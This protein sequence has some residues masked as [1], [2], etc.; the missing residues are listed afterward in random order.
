MFRYNYIL[1]K[2]PIEANRLM[3]IKN[4]TNLTNILGQDLKLGADPQHNLFKVNL[5]ELAQVTGVSRGILET[6]HTFF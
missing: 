1:E 5:L 6:L 3:R 4:L 2:M